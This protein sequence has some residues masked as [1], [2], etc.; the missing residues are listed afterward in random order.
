MM[1]AAFLLADGDPDDGEHRWL[2]VLHAPAAAEPATE[3]GGEPTLMGKE[4][5]SLRRR[6]SFFQKG[7]W[8]HLERAHIA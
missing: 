5:G 7:L 2:S 8:V 1:N 3:G 6:L 4:V